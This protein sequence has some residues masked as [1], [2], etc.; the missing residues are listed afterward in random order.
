MAA[1]NVLRAALWMTGAIA[2]FTL[3]A[4]AGRAT[5]STHDTFEMMM[6]RSVIG[7]IIVCAVLTW[8][9]TWHRVSRDRLGLNM[10]RNLAHFIG[11]NLWFYSLTLIPLAQVFALE[12]T[13]PLWVILL[14]PLLLGERITLPKALAV[15]LG[16]L[17]ILVVARPGA[18]PL[19]S[20]IAAAASCAIFFALTMIATKRLTRTEGIGSI[21]FW[22][23][24][25]QLV[26]GLVASGY[27]AEIA[28]PTAATIPWLILIGVCGLTAHFCITKALAIAPATIVVPFDFARLPIIA[29]V[30]ALIYHE[31]IDLFVFIGGIMILSANYVNVKTSLA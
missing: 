25:M 27:D 22:L 26:L 3:M 5:A 28:L 13:T 17:G 31:P 6:Y 1:A 29:I 7:I 8:T 2:S 23:T 10:A 24:S 20:G 21:L 11:Q 12:F 30:G 9:G 15:G 19:N 16:F 14:A 18:T 4:V